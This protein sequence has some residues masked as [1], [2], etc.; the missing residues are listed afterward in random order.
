MKHFKI[1]LSLIIFSSQIFAKTNRVEAVQNATL[2]CS[3]ILQQKESDLL[4]FKP[5]N[6]DDLSGKGVSTKVIPLTA[7]N[8]LKADEKGAF[9]WNQDSK[10]NS[11]WYNPPQRGIVTL[12]N[13]LSLNYRQEYTSKLVRQRMR[14]AEKR[15]WKITFDQKFDKVIEACAKHTRKSFTHIWLLPEVIKAFK[16][17]HR[18]GHAHSIEVW[19]E[20]GELIG[21][22]YGLYNSGVFTSESSFFKESNA[23]KVAMFAIFI[24]L[25]R[26]GFTHVDV[27]VVHSVSKSD[28]L[29]KYVSR[30]EFLNIRKSFSHSK[31]NPFDIPFSYDTTNYGSEVTIKGF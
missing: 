31:I 8:V 27:Q 28:F 24:H 17:L 21:G 18:Q 20:K 16:K 12:K 10:E 29:A 30:E 6:A 11:F 4:L 7:E 14:N 26:L 23:G 1:S 9:V 3:S 25:Y 15:K 19:N 2:P 22:T 13:L 5:L